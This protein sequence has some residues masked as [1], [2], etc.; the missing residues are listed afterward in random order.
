MTA[1]VAKSSMQK[2]SGAKSSVVQKAHAKSKR[3]KSH[4]ITL[5]RDMKI[6]KNDE[7]M[8]SESQR[9]YCN[10]DF[11]LRAMTNNINRYTNFYDIKRVDAVDVKNGR[12]ISESTLNR[13][14]MSFNRIR[15]I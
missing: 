8:S 12:E 14:L 6:S 3:G 15:K 10:V 7:I 2:F 11:E 5:Q 13:L 9:S 1:K 4:D